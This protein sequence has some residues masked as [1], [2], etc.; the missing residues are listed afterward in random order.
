MEGLSRNKFRILYVIV[1]WQIL[2]F[3]SIKKQGEGQS[4]WLQSLN[5]EEMP[6]LYRK[7]NKKLS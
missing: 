2:F 3:F 4:H 5:H 6:P 1:I 7:E